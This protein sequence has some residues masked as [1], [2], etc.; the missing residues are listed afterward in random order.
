MEAIP[1][2]TSFISDKRQ[3]ADGILSF[4]NPDGFVVLLWVL[5]ASASEAVDPF[6]FKKPFPSFAQ[7]SGLSIAPLTLRKTLLT[8]I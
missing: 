4:L 1:S 8:V 7:E 3:L 6:S 5:S 2:A